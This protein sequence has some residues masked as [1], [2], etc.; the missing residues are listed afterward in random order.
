MTLIL[1]F[2][3]ETITALYAILTVVISRWLMGL[4]SPEDDLRWLQ[5]QPLVRFLTRLKW[6]RGNEFIHQVRAKRLL[7]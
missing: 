6:Y 4:A 2:I 3:S 5:E 1:T 7:A